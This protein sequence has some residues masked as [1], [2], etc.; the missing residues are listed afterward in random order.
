MRTKRFLFCF[1]LVVLNACAGGTAWGQASRGTILGRTA[2]GADRYPDPDWHRTTNWK[3]AATSA[4]RIEAYA[5]WLREHAGG[6][7]AAVVIKN[8]YLIFEGRGARSHIRQKNNCG[9]IL[10]PLQATVLGAALYQGKLRSLDENAIPYWKDP[11]ATRYENDRF[12]T[13]R[14]FAQYHDRWNEPAPPGTFHYNNASATAAGACIAGL[15]REVN[16]PRPKGI[17]EVAR[18]E[19]AEKIRADWDLWYW[20]EDFTEQTGDSGPQLVLESSVYELAKLG[21]L[22]LRRGRWK[23]T[24]IFAEDY[25]REAV[26][27]WSPD[28]GDTRFGYFGHYGY[29]WFVNDRQALLP[30]VPDD[31]FYAIGNGEPKRA[32]VLMT[33]PSLDTVAVLSM[34]RISDDGRWDVIQNSRLPS[35]EGPRLW[36]AEVVKLHVRDYGSRKF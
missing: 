9:S 23:N 20:E 22:W 8:G 27:D 26:T 4:E 12:I 30:D 33:I 28:T 15:F 18:K 1:I 3:D 36:A 7:W 35:N 34:E 29:W 13:F 16:G 19:V 24:R 5:S 10:K 25:Y 6:S 14:Q 2:A 17:A 31:A 32:T 11:F 21:Y